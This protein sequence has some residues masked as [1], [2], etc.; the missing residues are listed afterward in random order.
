MTYVE[1]IVGRFGGVRPMAEKIGYPVSTVMS[2]KSRGS[3]P[4]E[5]KPKVLHFAR[6]N[7]LELTEVD[8]F[9]NDQLSCV[10]A[11]DAA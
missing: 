5:H 1:K 8:F 3:I 2:W 10:R 7:D 11:G 4:D 9:P 6:E